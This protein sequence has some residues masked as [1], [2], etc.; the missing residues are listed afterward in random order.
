MPQ[1][2]KPIVKADPAFIQRAVWRT[3]HH[4]QRFLNRCSVPVEMA[5]PYSPIRGISVS[6]AAI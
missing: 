6:I 1:I 4:T 5:A 2:R 3:C